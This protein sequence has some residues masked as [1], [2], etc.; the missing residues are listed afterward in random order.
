MRWTGDVERGAWIGSRL[1]GPPGSAGSIVP[2]GFEAYARVLHPSTVT[3]YD[4]KGHGD[5]REDYSEEAWTWARIAAHTGTVI[6]PQVQWIRVAGH[7]YDPILL[8]GGRSAD[9]PPLGHLDPAVLAHVM[10]IAGGHTGTPDDV[11]AALWEGWAIDAGTV[12]F[13]A[14]APE[15][16]AE[17]EDTRSVQPQRPTVDRALSELLKRGPF[18]ELP[19]RRYVLLATGA[20]ELTDPAWPLAAGMG[21]TDRL[22]GPMPQLIWPSDHAWAIASEIDVDSTLIG[23]TYRLIN[24]LMAHPAIEAVRVGET[25]DLTWDAD[26]INRVT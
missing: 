24:E 4:P 18:L 13:E 1:N 15:G 8:P 2:S 22:P 3:R 26:D 20:P 16:D 17:D 23:G 11:T 25:T 10:T 7:Q 14:F 21:W 9:P 5:P 19:G 6:H 12:W